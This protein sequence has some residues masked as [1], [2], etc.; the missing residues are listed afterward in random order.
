MPCFHSFAP[1]SSR[2]NLAGAEG[3][4]PPSS[5]LETDSLA[6]ELTPLKARDQKPENREQIRITASGLLFPISWF[7]SPDLLRFLV[8][9]VLAAAITELLEFQTAG[10]RLLVLR[11]RVVPL[12]ALRALQ[13]N[14]FPHPQIL[15]K[16]VFCCQ[17]VRCSEYN[18]EYYA[19]IRLVPGRRFFTP[20]GRK[21]VRGDPALLVAST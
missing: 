5:V 17:S 14:D 21:P 20:H 2:L 13:N 12:L 8:H 3:F 6:V 18:Q 15:C 7:L 4:E 19:L 1:D 9:L 11:R 16:T 10:G